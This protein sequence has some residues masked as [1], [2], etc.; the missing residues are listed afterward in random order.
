[1]T[2]NNKDDDDS[3][4]ILSENLGNSS[5][6]FFSYNS[7]LITKI[8]QCILESC[9]VSDSEIGNYLTNLNNINFYILLK[10]LFS[11]IDSVQGYMNEKNEFD[12]FQIENVGL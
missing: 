2:V 1:M 6:H 12:E 10:L 7:T 3:I 5:L 11:L 4:R 8:I 9:K